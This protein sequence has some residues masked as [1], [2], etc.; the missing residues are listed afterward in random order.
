M[1]VLFIVDPLERLQLAGDTSYALMLECARRG[2]EVW[3]C[4]ID[5]LG[6]EHDD[7]IAEAQL[8]LVRPAATWDEAFSLEERTPIP[9]EAFDIVLMRKDPPVDVAY[10][11]AT[12]ILEMARGKT[13]VVND[14][15][16]LRELNEHLAVLRFPDLTPPTLVTRSARRLQAFLREQGGAI[17]VKPVD[18]YGGLGV[19]VVKVGDQNT[20]SIF[21]TSTGAGTR[22]TMAQKYLPD[23]VKGDK[24]ILLVDGEP[25]GAV[26]RVPAAAEARGNLHVGGR[27]VKATIDARDREIIAAVAPFLREHGQ[28]L[29][30]LDVIGGMLTEINVTSPT[31]VRHIEA[32]EHRNVAA[33]ILDCF[34]RKAAA[35]RKA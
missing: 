7:P 22:W 33:P 8:T 18:G 28:I 29:V 14:P 34:E 15:S 20:S 12:W 10:V 21:E 5:H 35:R 3:T 11:Q 6:L 30:G 24:R 31:G 32:L 17:V 1:R 2:H 13:L 26:L 9:L 27:P 4:Q 16:G 25:V 19:F 23:V